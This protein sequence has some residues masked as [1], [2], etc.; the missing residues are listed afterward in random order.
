MD[1]TDRFLCFRAVR[2]ARVLNLC[3]LYALSP[4]SQVEGQNVNLK[5]K[6]LYG[7]LSIGVAIAVVG[8]I[9][10][11]AVKSAGRAVMDGLLLVW[12]SSSWHQLIST[13]G[14]LLAI[15]GVIYAVI[16]VASLRR[17]LSSQRMLTHSQA[18]LYGLKEGVVDLKSPEA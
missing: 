14:T 18:I 13:A 16:Q 11:D 10:S 9:T 5:R 6:R 12:N 4:K 2:A 3:P 17:H 7:R 1:E 15:G 8:S